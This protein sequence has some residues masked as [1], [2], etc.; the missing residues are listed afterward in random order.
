MSGGEV[1]GFPYWMMGVDEDFMTAMLCDLAK[2][3][4]TFVN[5]PLL[6]DDNLIVEARAGSWLPEGSPD[7][8]P[9][10]KCTRIPH[11]NLIPKDSTEG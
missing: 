5:S 8:C 11:H 10:S 7:F 6:K 9:S 2:M 3:H 4:G 1:T